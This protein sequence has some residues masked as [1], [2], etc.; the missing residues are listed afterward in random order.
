MA[1]VD[2]R[3]DPVGVRAARQVQIWTILGEFR[4]GRGVIRRPQAW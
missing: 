1:D 4:D 2:P 3:D